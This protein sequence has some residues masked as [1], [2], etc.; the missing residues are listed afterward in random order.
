VWAIEHR[1][2]DVLHAYDATTLATELYNSNQVPKQR[3]QFGTA[4]HFGTPVIVNGK[5]Y[6]GTK[7]GVAVSGLLQH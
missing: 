2:P 1:N 7:K 6:V 4:T 3:D 5:V